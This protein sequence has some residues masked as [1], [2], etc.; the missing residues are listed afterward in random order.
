[1]P[2]LNFQKQFVDQIVSGQKCQTIRAHRKDER[3]HA[4][5]GKHLTLYTGMRTK[6]CRRIGEAVVTEIQEVTI[7]RDGIRLDC[8]WLPVELYARD[9]HEPTIDEFARADG[10]ED[11]N[12]MRDWFEKTHGK[13][14]FDGM[15]IKWGAL[16][17]SDI[18]EKSE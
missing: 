16:D 13:L 2:A 10:F 4:T 14:P 9:Q 5:V 8:S 15:L 1:M 17:T 11:F 6:S 3:A 12:D 18:G 7:E